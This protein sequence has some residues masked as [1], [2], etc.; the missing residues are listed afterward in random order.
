MVARLPGLPT[1][2]QGFARRCPT[3]CPF[4]SHDQGLCICSFSLYANVLEPGR[5]TR[6]TI[7]ADGKYNW[8]LPPDCDIYKKYKGKELRK[9]V[10]KVQIVFGDYT[11]KDEL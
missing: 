1:P 9:D 7:D 4:R 5:Y 10:K 3:D 11:L 8:H 2:D 6:M